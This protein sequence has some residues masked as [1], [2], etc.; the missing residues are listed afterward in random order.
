MKT[1]HTFSTLGLLLLLIGKQSA[2]F[3]QT[4]NHVF[5]SA[6]AVNYG[7]IDLP[8]P[9]SKTW[10][11]DRAATPGYFGAVGAASYANPSDAHNINGYTK[12]YANA[13]NQSF[14][15]PVGSG[16]DYRS[17]SLSGSRT[18]SSVVGVAWI[19]G[20]PTDNLDPTAP[21]A[22]GHPIATV[23]TGI[24]A[25]SNVGQWD[26]Q[27]ISSDAAGVTVTVSIP[28]LSAFGTATEL[29]LVGWNGSQWQNLSGST[30]ATGNVENSTLSGTM[31]A[32][33]TALGIGK[34]IPPC[35]VS[36]I[37]PIL[38]KN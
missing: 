5:T 10:S 28:D 27:D 2:L 36:D 12:H 17:L 11:T 35:L 34:A 30:G 4:G 13:A 18:T 6:E 23:G 14:S 9:T 24:Q 15:F 20:D 22:G 33:I 38:V 26:W 25:V 1:K 21:N 19:S 29:R 31:I 8:T 3:A 37:T 16:T 7:V 32:G